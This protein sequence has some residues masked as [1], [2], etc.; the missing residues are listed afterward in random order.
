MVWAKLWVAACK[1][2]CT[3]AGEKTTAL[4]QNGLPQ[5]SIS[6]VFAHQS[7]FSTNLWHGIKREWLA[8]LVSLH[9]NLGQHGAEVDISKLSESCSAQ[10]YVVQKVPFFFQRP[11][12]TSG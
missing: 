10:R 1:S 7:R 12:P 8:F 11:K 3:R 6:D 4:G 5:W 9:S 2:L